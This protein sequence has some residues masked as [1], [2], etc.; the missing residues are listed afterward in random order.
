MHLRIFGDGGWPAAAAFLK[1]SEGSLQVEVPPPEQWLSGPNIPTADVHVYAVPQRMALGDA[2]YHVATEATGASGKWVADDYSEPISV[3]PSSL[4]ERVAAL[5]NILGRARKAAKAK[6]AKKA[7]DTETPAAETY[8]SVGIIILSTAERFGYWNRNIRDNITRQTYPKAK[9]SFFLVC[10]EGLHDVIQEMVPGVIVID[11]PV[12]ATIGAKR[13]MGCAAAVAA[14]CE[15]LA[16][17]DD[18]DYY[19]EKSVANRVAALR[20]PNAQKAGQSIVFCSSLPIFDARQNTSMMHV[21]PTTDAPESR[22]SEASLAFTRAAWLAQQFPISI[23]NEG[24]SEGYGFLSGRMAETAEIYPIDVI[25]AL[26]HFGNAAWRRQIMK[27]EKPTG[28][29]WKFPG[30]YSQWLVALVQ[31]QAEVLRSKTNV[32]P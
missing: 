21:I 7:T 11:A 30:E 18:D 10:D 14:G 26:V 29:I 28:C 22:C 24:K 9:T 8:P 15:I 17:M 6:D 12:D 31:K 4:R 1:R 20:S 32:T 2:A 25:V 27:V 5:R 16:M 3:I 13:N 23:P 19:P